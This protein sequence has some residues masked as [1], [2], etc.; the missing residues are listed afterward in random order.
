MQETASLASASLQAEAGLK[1]VFNSEQKGYYRRLTKE[2]AAIARGRTALEMRAEND[3]KSLRAWMSRK[4]KAIEFLETKKMSVERGE[5]DISQYAVTGDAMEISGRIVFPAALRVD[6][7]DEGTEILRECIFVIENGIGIGNGKDYRG[8][9]T[10]IEDFG[11]IIFTANKPDGTVVIVKEDG[12][13]IGAG[14]GYTEINYL[15]IVDGEL[16][17]SAKGADGKWRI[18]KAG[19]EEIV[20]DAYSKIGSM[21]KINNR[22]MFSAQKRSAKG[23][24]EWVVADINGNEIGAD[25]GYSY[26]GGLTEIDG[27]IMFQA[28]KE[29]GE[30][31]IVRENG[32]EIYFSGFNYLYSPQKILGRVMFPAHWKDD[33]SMTI[34]REDGKVLVPRGIFSSIYALKEFNGEIWFIAKGML[35]QKHIIA[36]I[37]NEQLIIVSQRKEDIGLPEKICGR[38]VFDVQKPNKKWVVLDEAENEISE[39]FGHIYLIKELDEKRFYVIG[40]MEDKIVRR[41]YNIEN[42]K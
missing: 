19:G 23:T 27:K 32:E 16:I 28:D 4:R 22:I 31:A 13:E 37:S 21:K 5:I 29:A 8:I 40:K 30:S 41:I 39:E 17:F 6:K 18:V 14:R 35:G 1:R 26:V 15:E 20:L 25:K 42:R 24:N 33:F 36:K 10:F 12:T 38:S 3:L 7:P 2:M 9:G 11:E 34:M